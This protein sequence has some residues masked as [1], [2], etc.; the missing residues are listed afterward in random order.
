[1]KKKVILLSFPLIILAACFIPF[2]QQKNVIVKA[3]FFDSYQQLSK[4]DN[5]KKWRTD[6]RK[7][8]L[9]DST[10]ISDKQDTNGFE[11][12]YA[13]TKLRVRL[14]NGNS[15]SIN[16]NNANKESEYSYTVVPQKMSNVT[17]VIVIEKTNFI[18][19]LANLIDNRS[20]EGTHI[21]DYK[22]FMENPDLFYGYKIVKSKVIDTS[23]VV[24]KRV[25]LAKNKFSEAAKSLAILNQYIASKGLKQTQPLMAQFFPKA[26]DSVQ[27]NIGLPVNG[28]VTATKPIAFME[29]PKSGNL[30]VVKYHG[31]FSDRLKVYA[32]VQKFFNDR[33]LPMPILPFETY[34]DNK[35]PQSDSDTINIQINFTTF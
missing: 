2:T 30:Y 24:L 26:N 25:V 11:L 19:Y 35:L 10:K 20:F 1:M 21:A 6:L 18:K 32:A 28:K 12:N 15:F 34:L 22:S 14:V 29:M 3:S 9:A 16:E 27:L 17:S 33:T 23:I 31:K 5:W 13:D 7:A 4:A 8:L